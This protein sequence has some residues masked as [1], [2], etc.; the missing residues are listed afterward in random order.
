MMY[1]RICMR[2]SNL[3]WVLLIVMS[4]DI[5]AFA[6]NK[7]QKREQ[8]KP[9]AAQKK[10]QDANASAKKSAEASAAVAKLEQDA[11]AADAA[12]QAAIKTLA[13]AG[14]KCTALHQK[15]TESIKSQS[16][17]TAAKD[18]IA[19]AKT[20]RDQAQQSLRDAQT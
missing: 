19:S 2:R 9:Q 18:A 13:D 15:F 14:A 7:Q 20:K 3:A 16:E 6:Q 5:A 4:L 8:E 12:A 17:F 11:I 1:N 10:E